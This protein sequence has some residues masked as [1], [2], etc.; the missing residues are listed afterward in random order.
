MT[1]RSTPLPA[2][3]LDLDL[4]LDHA[5]RASRPMTMERWLC[6]L[7]ILVG[8]V[9][10][11]LFWGARTSLWEDELI[12][13]T[14]GLQP[15][16]SFLTEM[17]RNDIH[18][19]VWFL[20]LKGWSALAP[21][22]DRWAL[23]SSLVLGLLS[24][25][26][27]HRVALRYA[28]ARAALWACAF[29]CVLP[30]FAW[31]AGT[32]RMYSWVPL[33]ALLN[34]HLGRQLLQGGMNRAGGARR[35][36]AVLLVAVQLL[37]AYSHAI[38]FLFVGLIAINVCWFDWASADRASRKRWAW[39]QAVT[40]VAMLPLPLSALA[41]G[42]EPLAPSNWTAL[43]RQPAA[44]IAGWP[45]ENDATVMAVGGI[46][47]AMLALLGAQSP[48]SRRIL[49]GLPVTGLLAAWAIG[50]MGKPLFKSPVF[51][52]NLLPFL[53][54]AAGIGAARLRGGVGRAGAAAVLLLLA[55]ATLP[56][57]R[58]MSPGEQFKPAAQAVAAAARPGDV[59]V[60]PN[61]SVFW[62]VMRY[63]NTAQWGRPL[64]VM[65]PDNAS[66]EALKRKL[67]PTWTS[68]LGLDRT[69]DRVD[70]GGITYIVGE[71]RDVTVPA[72]GSVWLVQRARYASS[73][74]LTQPVRATR[75]QWFGRELSVQQLQADPAGALMISNPSAR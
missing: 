62:G 39:S 34:W 54:I 45:L 15:V 29:F 74:G 72:G 66:W 13:V 37:L 73:V 36:G 40:A 53:A 69:T 75:T 23:T 48:E 31:A 56:W 60:V 4:D 59:V 26:T 68:R 2:T 9:G 3:D 55:G 58:L 51:A 12:A 1:L 6:G 8:L 63:A 27:L 18:P 38:E 28:G 24:A 64:E 61:V 44:M 25:W 67:G 19:A 33:L 43:F 50:L 46:V 10:A 5:A 17:L 47:F 21:A 7:A 65:P 41:R 42:T 57:S 71:P 16:S 70:A 49:L 35:G 30:T 52:A 32:L 22:S 20:L 14:H 11:V